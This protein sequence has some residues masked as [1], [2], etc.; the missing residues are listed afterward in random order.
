MTVEKL[1]APG[2]RARCEELAE[3][4]SHYHD[5]RW[6]K[7]SVECSEVEAHLAECPRCAEL[8]DD[9]RAITS[10]ARLVRSTDAP[11]ADAE[12]MSRRV[13]TR[14]R[15]RV[16]MRRLKWAGAGVAFAAAAA[17]AVVALMVLPGTAPPPGGLAREEPKERP[18]TV[19][20]ESV[21]R[22]KSKGEPERPAAELV[23]RADAEPGPK[24]ARR[25]YE[26]LVR[27]IEELRR[28]EGPRPADGVHLV[29]RTTEPRR[30]RPPPA[31][32]ATVAPAPPLLGVVLGH[33]GEPDK[34]PVVFVEGVVAG[35]PA[36]RAGLKS[37]DVVL[38]IDAQSVRGRSLEAVAGLIRRA[39]PGA[40]IT[41]TYARD[42]RT[43]KADVTLAGER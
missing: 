32:R 6:P 13:R 22:E 30:R 7:G 36:D 34:T 2:E 8:L 10:A 31:P 19:A 37:G 38:A 29:G 27:R 18:G 17:A 11:P 40:R 33:R 14:L 4:I 35:S 43:R 24:K 20:P 25:D 42:G 12:R 1:S 16:F 21:R 15:S 23:R 39:G 5:D 41:I 26:E 28:R 9:Y 3:R